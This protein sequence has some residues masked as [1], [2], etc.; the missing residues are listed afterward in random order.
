MIDLHTHTNNSDGSLSV[1]KLLEEAQEKQIDYLSITDHDTVNAYKELPKYR[2]RFK[3]KI[4]P[5]IEMKCIYKGVSIEVLG[6]GIDYKKMSELVQNTTKTQTIILNKLLLIADKLKLK[7]KKE[8]MYIDNKNPQKHFAAYVFAKGII[9]NN[10]NN[11]K[12]DCY[13]KFNENTFYRIHQSNPNSIFYVEERN[14]Y[15]DIN[16]AISKIHYC[17]GLAF[18]AHGFIYPYED[19]KKVMEEILNNT[20]IDGLECMHSE[21]TKEEMCIA[22]SLCKKYTKLKS[23][24]SDYHGTNKKD[25][26]LLTGKNNNLNIE[27]NLINE[28][29]NKI[30]FV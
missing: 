8:E 7:Y 2:N 29:I 15:E 21:F 3:G 25:I 20:K 17:G 22:K 4:I 30:K 18:L 11:E 6:Y 13:T 24:G 19:N 14:I 26:K 16:D 28:W 23:G 9:N 5:G 27:N 10:E 1:E 12:L